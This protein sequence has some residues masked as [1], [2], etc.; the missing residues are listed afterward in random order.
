MDCDCVVDASAPAATG[1]F[2]VVTP[3]GAVGSY[4]SD[5]AL[6]WMHSPFCAVAA[7]L[8]LGDCSDT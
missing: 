3:F 1:A 6:V 4:W 2:P 7:F 5:A 8:V